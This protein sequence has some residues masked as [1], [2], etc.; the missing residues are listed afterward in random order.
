M[1]LHKKTLLV[2]AQIKEPRKILGIRPRHNGRR[3]N[4]HIHRQLNKFSGNGV[5]RFHDQTARFIGVLGHTRSLAPNKF[6]VLFNDTVVKFFISFTGGP[7][8]NIKLIDIGGCF[9][10]EKVSE[11]ERIHAAHAAAMLIMIFIA[12]A[13]AV[14]NGNRLRLLTV[15]Q[16]DFTAGRPRRIKESF[17]FQRIIDAGIFAV[18]VLDQRPGIHKIIARSH[19]HRSNFH[20]NEAVLLLK[21]N[22]FLFADFFAQ[23]AFTF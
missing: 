8:V 20:L 14:Q 7:Y 12:T 21:I 15:A 18:T 13:D 17:H 9:F 4:D 2:G 16:R 1:P 5:F 6:Y 19:N 10:F 23:A 22:R 3:K 11:L